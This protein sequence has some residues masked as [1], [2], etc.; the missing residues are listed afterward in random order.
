MDDK[1]LGQPCWWLNSPGNTAHSKQPQ[2]GL[3]PLQHCVGAG[4]TA[5]CNRVARDTVDVQL[6]TA[7]SL[8]G[9]YAPCIVCWSRAH[10]RASHRVAERHSGMGKPTVELGDASHLTLLLP[11][12]VVQGQAHLCQ[13][14]ADAAACSNDWR[15]GLPMG[16]IGL[17]AASYHASAEMGTQSHRRY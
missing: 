13:I 14:N 8:D 2:W 6:L 12:I 16:P 1:A 4:H 17:Q 11:T 10:R 15:L 9:V 5:V 3:Y 7:S